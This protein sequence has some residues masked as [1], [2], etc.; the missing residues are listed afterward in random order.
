V[1]RPLIVVGSTGGS[2]SALDT[3]QNPITVIPT[4]G[5][6]GAKPAGVSVTPDGSK[7][8]VSFGSGIRVF[9]LTVNP[10]AYLGDVNTDSIN[11]LITRDGRFVLTTRGQ[12][13]AISID[14]ISRAV[15]S[16]L[17]LPFAG[18]FSVT[19]DNS[20]VIVADAN[21]NVFRT[22]SL[23]SL[24]VLT[25]TGKTASYTFSF[26]SPNI[27]MAPNGRF[28]L[29]ANPS[30][31]YVAIL[32]IDSQHNVTVS[33]T[34]LPIST[35]PWGID[36]TPDGTKAYVTVPGSSNISVLSID[37]N[38]N[39]TD[40]GVRI[41][42]ANGLPFVPGDLNGGPAGIAIAVDGRA[43]I[44]NSQGSVT[45]VDTRTDTVLGTVTVPA[46]ASGIGVPR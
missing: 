11:N 22:L 42:I 35:S 28:A 21:N 30:G 15:I 1:A 39:V 44:S 19:P 23:S 14:V 26:W 33:G 27:A 41:P 5:A 45:I 13:T 36:I 38:D 2:I 20:T 32:R 24:G 40:T 46:I 29:T 9:N 6:F 10:P 8:F 4:I 3:S 7:A 37:S 12:D 43:Y 18:N 25:D 31:N 34:R 17:K 16:A